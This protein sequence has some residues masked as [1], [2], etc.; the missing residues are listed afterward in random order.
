MIIDLTKTK[1]ERKIHRKAFPIR[2]DCTV[3]PALGEKRIRIGWIETP[4]EECTWVRWEDC[5]AYI[6]DI[7]GWPGGWFAVPTRDLAAGESDK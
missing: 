7:G 2:E 6:K 5:P 3:L 1:T 4:M